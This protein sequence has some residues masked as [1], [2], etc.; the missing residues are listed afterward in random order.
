M[1]GLAMLFSLLMGKTVLGNYIYTLA[2]S[3]RALLVSGIN[4]VRI[5]VLVYTLCGMLAAIGGLLMTARLGV[6]APTAAIGYELDIIA[7]AV[8][9]GASLFGSEGST[10]GALLGAAVMQMF[11]NGLVLLG[12]PAYWQTAALG[13]VILA[14]ILVD[15]WRRRS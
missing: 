15:H 10:L 7:A 13:T 6:A 8:I 3:E 4:V 11:R 1:L 14:F 12:F 2:G 5:K 9:G